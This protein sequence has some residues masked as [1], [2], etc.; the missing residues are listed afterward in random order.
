MP[1][2]DSHDR[3]RVER[4]TMRRPV[5]EPVLHELAQRAAAAGLSRRSFLGLLGA[6]GGAAAL[7]ACGGTS[8]PQADIRWANW[9]MYIDTAD[10]GS[11]PSIEQFEEQ[12]GLTVE[13]LEDID[14][15][16]SFYGK[17]QG[18]LKAKQ[19]IGFDA[20]IL[21]NWMASRWIRA[22]YAEKRTRP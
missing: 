22:G 2:L 6:A 16:D 15:L 7:S 3:V 18:Q 5:S 1:R 4:H 21:A 20:V 8:K 9:T 12:S 11:Y 17:V 14:D 19:D 13:Y 10:D